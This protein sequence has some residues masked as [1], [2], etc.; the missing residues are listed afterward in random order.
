MDAFFVELSE[1]RGTLAYLASMDLHE[2]SRAVEFWLASELIVFAVSEVA[3][4]TEGEE[5]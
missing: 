3:Y 4:E 1:I 2:I 5:E